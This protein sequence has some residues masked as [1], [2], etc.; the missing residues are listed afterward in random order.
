MQIKNLAR[1]PLFSAKAEIKEADFAVALAKLQETRAP[2]GGVLLATS[3][4]PSDPARPRGKIYSN[5]R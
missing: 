2:G 4:T 1:I 5:N 3:N